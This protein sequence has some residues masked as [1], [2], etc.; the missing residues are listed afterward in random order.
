MSHH[1]TGTG[2]LTIAGIVVDT[3]DMTEHHSDE[4]GVDGPTSAV[5]HIFGRPEEPA[6]SAALES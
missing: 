4:G 2:T 3:V 5:I 6:D 1:V